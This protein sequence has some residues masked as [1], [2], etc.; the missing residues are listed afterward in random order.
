MLL[1]QEL[2]TTPIWWSVR[3]GQQTT[4]VHFCRVELARLLV[5]RG[6]APDPD[7][8]VGRSYPEQGIGLQETHIQDD[9]APRAQLR[10]DRRLVRGPEPNAFDT[11][12][13]GRGAQPA[14]LV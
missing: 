7:S 8:A 14:A 10:I 6:A 11:F 4:T 1:R 3:E 13:R 5:P 12:G 2:V 9:L